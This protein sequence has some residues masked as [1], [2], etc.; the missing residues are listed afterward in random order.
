MDEMY[1]NCHENFLLSKDLCGRN[2]FLFKYTYSNEDIKLMLELIRLLDDIIILIICMTIIIVLIFSNIN[3]SCRNDRNY[4]NKVNGGMVITFL[5]LI[6]SFQL[7]LIL[8]R[9]IKFKFQKNFRSHKKFRIV[10]VL[11]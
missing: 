11:N 10:K 8:Y 5:L 6:N 7:K 9:I 1:I 3:S 4:R 2:F